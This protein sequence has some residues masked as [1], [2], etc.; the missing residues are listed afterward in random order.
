MTDCFNTRQSIVD[1]FYKNNIN[2]DTIKI[3]S[4]DYIKKVKEIVDFMYLIMVL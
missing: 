4:F 2:K 3:L 1:I